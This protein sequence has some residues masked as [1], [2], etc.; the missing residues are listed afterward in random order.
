MKIID[1]RCRPAFLHPFFGGVPGTAE[2]ATARWLNRR[3]GTRGPDNH[4]ES[5]L[6]LEGFL[7]T[8]ENAG[9]HKA[10]VVGRHTPSQHLP[11]DH[12]SELV[13]SDSR[14]IGIGSVE[15]VLQGVENAIAEIQRAT[16]KLQLRGINLE[17]GFAEPARHPDDPIYWPIYE[18]LQSHNIPLFLMTGPTTP[19]PAFNDPS[20]LAAVARNFPNLQI[21]AYH[22]YWPRVQEAVGLAFRYENI[23]LIPDMYLFQ[24]GSR[25]YVEAA[26]SFMADQILFGSSYTFRSIEQSIQDAQELG[27][28]EEVLE[29]FFYKNAEGLLGI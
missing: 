29:K 8:I 16:Q 4:F 7:Q 17:P 3:V 2:H 15:P 13:Q 24:A 14:L 5:S 1:M 10:V 20:P 18:Y 25:P 22:G 12:I 23:H 28:R 9:L 26:N 27:F 19:N 21:A 6:T 11:N